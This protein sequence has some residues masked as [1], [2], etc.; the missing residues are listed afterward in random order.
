MNNAAYK[1][2]L[3]GIV[4]ATSS[5]SFADNTAKIKTLID[6]ID[7]K[8]RIWVQKDSSHPSGEPETKYMAPETRAYLQTPEAKQL[9]QHAPDELQK[10]IIFLERMTHI[11]SRFA[12]YDPNKF[13][14]YKDEH[15]AILDIETEAAFVVNR[16]ACEIPSDEKIAKASAREFAQACKVFDL[17]KAYGAAAD[18]TWSKFSNGQEMSVWKKHHQEL[19]KVLKAIHEKRETLEAATPGEQKRKEAGSMEGAGYV[20]APGIHDIDRAAQH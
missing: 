14:S 7:A 2:L 15:Q 12:A 4:L 5:P 17:S 18:F 6:T 20:D 1:S 19:V 8:A 10:N 13:H 3:V 16:H 9:L 11:K